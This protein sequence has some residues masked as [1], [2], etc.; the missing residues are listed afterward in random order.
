MEIYQKLLQFSATIIT[1]RLLIRFVKEWKK[2]QSNMWVKG[3]PQMSKKMMRIIMVVGQCVTA[4]DT[5]AFSP[6]DTL[7]PEIYHWQPNS[8]IFLKSCVL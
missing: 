7:L 6:R 2:G 8:C 4:K 3:V 1:R 5:M